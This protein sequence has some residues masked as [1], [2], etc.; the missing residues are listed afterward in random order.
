MSNLTVSDFSEKK[1]SP[2]H[3]G[4]FPVN[5]CMKFDCVR[6]DTAECDGCWRFDKYEPVTGKV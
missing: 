4:N 6:H 2:K 1:R 5:G 3:R